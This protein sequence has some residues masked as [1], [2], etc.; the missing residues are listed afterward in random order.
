MENQAK[1]I[2]LSAELELRKRLN[3]EYD[4]LARALTESP[5]SVAT[6]GDVEALALLLLETIESRKSIEKQEKQLKTELKRHFPE[7]AG[8]LLAGSVVAIL[9]LITRTDV[10]RELIE[11]E[12]GPTFLEKYSKKTQYEK[13]TLKKK[14]G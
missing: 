2:D 7:G 10:D 12:L 13:L 8:I 9:D 4:V 5:L 14:G 1:Q 3:A 6:P 11:R